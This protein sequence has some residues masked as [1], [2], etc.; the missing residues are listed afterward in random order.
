MP[1]GLHEVDGIMKRQRKT[2]RVRLAPEPVAE[3]HD[4]VAQLVGFG[5]RGWLN[6]IESQDIRAWETVWSRYCAVLGTV[7]A[8]FVVTE[9]ECWTRCV[10]RSAQ[11]RIGVACLDCPHL[12]QDERLAVS[13]VAAAQHQTCP[14]MRACAFT[15]LGTSEIEP[16]IQRSQTF[17]SVLLQADQVLAPWSVG[18]GIDAVMPDGAR[19]H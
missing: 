3:H 5:F 6:G 19:L 13:I 11:R 15:L 18:P 14:A 12:C 2:R 10:H 9:L 7:Q 8:R 4:D 17:A 1:C 16:V